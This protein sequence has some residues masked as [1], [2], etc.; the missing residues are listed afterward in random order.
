MGEL[1]NY[2]KHKKYKHKENGNKITYKQKQ[3]KKHMHVNLV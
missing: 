2:E 1:G 3:L